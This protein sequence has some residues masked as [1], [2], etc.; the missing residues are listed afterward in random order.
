[1][2]RWSWSVVVVAL[3]LCVPVSS[4]ACDICN[5]SFQQTQTLRQDALQAKLIL[6]GTL[7]NPRLVGDKG[8][9][10]LRIEAV[11]KHDKFLGNTKVIELPRYLP[12]DPKEPPHFVV[13]CDIFNDKLDPYR[14]VPLKSK[15]AVEYLKGAM[16]LDVKDRTRTLLYYFR[17][18]DDADREVANDAFLE[19][20]KATN[21]EIGTVASKLAPEKLRGWLKD[22]QT[23]VNR[24]GLYAF[25][26]GACGGDQDA[27]FLRSLLEQPDS[28]ASSA[29]DGILAGYI[30]LRPREGWDLAHALLRD[31][32]KPFP[33]RY[34]AVRTQRFYHGWKP[35]ESRPQVLGGL[36]IALPQGDLADLALEDLR[37]WQM[38]DLTKDVLALYG[39]KSHDG[40]IVR[41]AIIRYALCCPKPEAVAFVA[42]RRKE[43]AGQVRDIEEALQ[44]EKLK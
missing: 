43:D 42:E 31:D 6:Y 32:K 15:N 41:R 5:F 11:L 12:V 33:V 27:A 38:W 26:L 23:P 4:R 39:R 36:A 8:A 18:L 20:A 34:A 7:E 44:F 2:I 13:F 22:V 1:M 37:R 14:G 24:L 3:E 29:L 35:E 9:T 30:Q 28:R 17:W 10:D 40:P 21:Q 25:L 16:T 19:F